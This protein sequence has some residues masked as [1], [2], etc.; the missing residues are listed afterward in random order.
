M[1][2]YPSKQPLDA[3]QHFIKALALE[4]VVAVSKSSRVQLARLNHIHKR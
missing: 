1:K 3:D 4:S 2:L